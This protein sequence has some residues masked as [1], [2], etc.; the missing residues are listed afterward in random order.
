MFSQ[1]HCRSLILCIILP[2]ILAS[3]NRAEQPGAK[4]EGPANWPQKV[5]VTVGDIRTR[6]DGPKMWTLS[7]IDYQNGVMATE[8]SAYGTVLTI[9]NAGRLRDVGQLAIIAA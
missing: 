2:T 8:D 7:G 1:R 4:K 6:I 3:A 9:R 5:V